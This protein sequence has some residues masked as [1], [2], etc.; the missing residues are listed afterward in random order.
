MSDWQLLRDYAEKNSD[1]AFAALLNRHMK[2]VYGTCRRDLRNS[3]LAEDATQAVFLLLAQKASTLRANG[4]ISGWLFN[5]ARLIASNTARI[6]RRRRYYEQEAARVMDRNVHR[7]H[8]LEDID[9]T[10]NDALSALSSADRELVMMRYFYDLSFQEIAVQIGTPENTAVQRVRRAIEKMR[11]YMSG[12]EVAVTSSALALL[13]VDRGAQAAPHSCY[14]ATAQAIQHHAAGNT[15]TGIA[16]Q[17]AAL[18]KGLSITMQTTKYKYAVAGAA[19]LCATVIAIVAVAAKMGAHVSNPSLA[20]LTRAA[21]A[22]PAVEPAPVKPQIV[23]ANEAAASLADT[24]DPF[25]PPYAARDLPVASAP[26]LP[27]IPDPIIATGPPTD[28]DIWDNRAMPPTATPAYA[29]DMRMVGELVGNGVW[30]VLQIGDKTVAVQPG[31]N[32]DAGKVVSIAANAVILR[33]ADSRLLSAQLSPTLT[34]THLLN[35]TSDWR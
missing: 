34:E 12:K 27:Q 16:P 28:H 19:L 20:T 7:E 31:D 18:L 25:K 13:L 4:S 33:T 29:N 22:S 6:E 2:L 26:S 35:A 32:T 17:L 10:L 9:I 30:A 24:P 5:A 11:R 1:A 21:T 3:Q 14:A 8:A 23:V 15:A